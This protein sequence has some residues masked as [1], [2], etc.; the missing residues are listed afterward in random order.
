NLIATAKRSPDRTALRLDNTKLTYKELDEASARVARFL[1]SFGVRPGDRVGVM[2]PNS[3]EFAILYYGI[4]R[5]GAVVVPMNVLF[6]SREISYQLNDCEAALLFAWSGFAAAAQ[7]GATDAGVDFVRLEEGE[8]QKITA[9]LIPLAEPAD[10]VATDT[11]VILYTSG[12][13]GKPK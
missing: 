2:L 4:L 6:K 3:L 7:S 10:R 13:T 1:Q 11:A 8:L 12:T 5:A 9:K